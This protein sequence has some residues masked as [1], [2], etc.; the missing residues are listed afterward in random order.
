MRF[1]ITDI[2]CN[3]N[4]GC[5][6]TRNMNS[7]LSTSATVTVVSAVAVA[8]PR[9]ALDQ[10]ELAEDAAFADLLDHV[11][12]ADDVDGAVEHGV[13]ELA[14]VAL[15]ED[16]LA[17]VERRRLARVLEDSDCHCWLQEVKPGAT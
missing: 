8:P 1:A 17:R 2:T 14:G 9:R 13:H 11:T 5:S 4:V 16:D 7:P 12:V 15:F 6:W 10:G 3:A